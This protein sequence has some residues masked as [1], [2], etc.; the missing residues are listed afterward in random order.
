MV[1]KLV[2]KF[3]QSNILRPLI[4]LEHVWRPFHCYINNIEKVK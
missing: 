2:T 3:V 1:N 4:G